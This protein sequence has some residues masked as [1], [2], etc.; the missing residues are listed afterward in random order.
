MRRL[1]HDI[2]DLAP[3]KALMHAHSAS[4]RAS[5]PTQNKELVMKRNSRLTALIF[6]LLPLASLAAPKAPPLLSERSKDIVTTPRHSTQSALRPTSPSPDDVGDADSFGRRST[7]LGFVGSI[8]LIVDAD[9]S[10]AGPEER[11]VTAVPPR[12]LLTLDERDLGVIHL[13]ANVTHSLVCFTLTPSVSWS[14]W[15]PTEASV[16]AQM[17]LLTSVIVQSEVFNGLIDPET[18]EPLDDGFNLTLG[19]Y[20]ESHFL[21]P[22]ASEEKRM[23]L[24]RGC[25]GG[26]VNRDM[27]RGLG[28]SETQVNAFFHK[29][30]TIHFGV[31]GTLA[32]VNQLSF[33]YGVRLYGD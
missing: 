31:L 22:S 8:P 5:T 10:G 16:N 2:R 17:N 33:A 14:F 27:L 1:S 7:Y 15:N 21:A 30:I 24:S 13:P 18:G 26:I 12:N 25:G 19:T 6:S 29:P 4:T 9:C 28:L 3:L 32:A 20:R 11:C 23:T